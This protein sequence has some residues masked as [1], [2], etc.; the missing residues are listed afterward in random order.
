MKMNKIKFVEKVRQC[1]FGSMAVAMSFGGVVATNTAN[2]FAADQSLNNNI[3]IATRKLGATKKTSAKIAM[4]SSK[5]VIFIGDVYTRTA[6][7]TSSNKKDKVKYTS[8]NSKIATVSSTGKITAK[9]R[10]TVTIT[11]FS[12]LD[13]KVKCSYQLKVIKKFKK[14]EKLFIAHRGYSSVAPEN[15]IPAFEAAAKKGFGAIECDIYETAKDKKGNRRFVIMHDS[16]LNRMCKLGS[17]KVYQSKLTYDTIRTKYYIKNGANVNKYSKSQLRIPTLEEYLSIC[18]KYNVKPVIEIKTDL[19]K[20]S[21]NRVYQSIKKAGLQNNATVISRYKQPLVDM[22]KKNKK[23]AI[24]L[25][26]NRI[27]NNII[28]W[29]KKY[30]AG[31]CMY[32]SL[33]NNSTVD[34]LNRTHKIY[35]N[36]W[37]I[38]S[39]EELSDYGYS[40]VGAITSN[41]ALWS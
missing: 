6:K 36:L 32:K 21:V 33:A 13:S 2:A 25:V 17:K 27:D 1:F 18:K 3:G 7:L 8:S 19:N 12:T 5:K 31:L 38:S 4:D 34:M 35:L 29:A 41:Y 24:Q 39:K 26:T 30:N 37:T 23:T 40:R 15:S 20:N 10:G 11:A 14:N 22:K 9:Q 16:T 28:K